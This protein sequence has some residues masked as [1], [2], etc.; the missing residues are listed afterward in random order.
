LVD[1]YVVTANPLAAT[2]GLATLMI[3][4]IYGGV[5]YLMT[6]KQAF[7]I[8]I[9]KGWGIFSSALLFSPVRRPGQ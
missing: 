7:I 3:V 1:K 9:E 6:H 4:G 5:G 2:V 8:K